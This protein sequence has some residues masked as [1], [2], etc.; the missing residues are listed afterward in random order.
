MPNLKKHSRW[1]YLLPAIHVCALL[2]SMI[3]HVI[4]SLQY[5]GIIWVFVMVVDLPVSALAYALGWSH[6]AIAAA[7]IFVVGTAWWYLLSLG[8]ESLIKR[9]KTRQSLPSTQSS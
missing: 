4:P 5:L 7:W 1:V 6:G 3:G 2:V 8:I 9:F